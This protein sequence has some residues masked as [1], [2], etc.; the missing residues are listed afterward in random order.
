V[1]DLEVVT[2]RM[3]ISADQVITGVAGAAVPGGAVLLDEGRSLA[4]GPRGELAG[5]AAFEDFPAL[6][7]NR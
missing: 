7:A 6:V 2:V 3:L 4:V 1:T 5:T